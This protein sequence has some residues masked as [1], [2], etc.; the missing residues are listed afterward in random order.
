[1]YHSITFTSEDGTSKNTWTDWGLIPSTRHSMAKREVWSNKVDVVG[2]N[3]QPDLV[4]PYHV[5]LG[6]NVNSYSGLTN[7]INKDTD[8]YATTTY[9]YSILKNGSGS[10][11]FIVAD[12]DRSWITIYSEIMNFMHGQ[13][14]KMIFAD[15]DPDTVYNV[16]ITVGGF[17][18][19]NNFSQISISYSLV[20]E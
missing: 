1:M 11:N 17:Q 2:V 7:L 10:F 14:T 15:D 4:R 19:G 5:S 16:L 20:A 13:K 9:E 18:S 3:S 8:D 6:L 12:Q